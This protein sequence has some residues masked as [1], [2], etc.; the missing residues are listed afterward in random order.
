MFS[1]P[2]RAFTLI[3]LMV[4]VAIF[5]IISAILVPAFIRAREKG[6]QKVKPPSR[7]AQEAIPDGLPPTLATAE[8]KLDAQVETIREG[9]DV[10]NRFVLKHQAQ[11]LF[12]DGSDEPRRILIPFPKAT[13]L[14]NL[15]IRVRQ[16]D[17]WVEPDGLLI[18]QD[19]VVWSQSSFPVEVRLDY[20]ATGEG[21]LRYDWPQANRVGKL[22]AQL[23]LEAGEGVRAPL[24]SLRPDQV[25]P[26]QYS[27]EA[28]EILSPSPI[29]LEFSELD[30]PLARVGKL[31]RLT[32]LAL[33]FF[34]AGFWYLAELYRRG[35]LK[36]FGFGSFFLLALTYCSFFVSVAVLGF[37]GSL[38]AP[39]YLLL[40]LVLS[41]PLLL[42]HVSQLMDWR[43]AWSRALPWSMATLI[44]VLMGVYTSGA[45]R[46]Y[47]YLSF[48]LLNMAFL[49]TTYKP[50]IR[51]QKERELAQAGRLEEA[52]GEFRDLVDSARDLESRVLVW[53]TREQT[54]TECQLKP[55]VER[56]L[57]EMRQAREFPEWADLSYVQQQT[58]RLE[59][60]LT[61]L[62]RLLEQAE[63]LVFQQEEQ[64]PA[65]DLPSSGELHCLICGSPS[66]GGTYC[67]CCG[68]LLPLARDCSSCGQEVV[69]PLHLLESEQ[70]YHCQS[71][72]A[73]PR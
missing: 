24:G 45:V 38:Q 66:R 61:K 10:E 40:A 41:Q 5:A 53:L 57:E 54:K 46:N 63:D 12:E 18:R 44:L 13:R 43:F 8:V 55:L 49:T 1:R 7:T 33:L 31:F 27:W 29:L 15:A 65:S 56:R 6:L 26:D 39:A 69:I 20:Q 9:L 62:N 30:S 73:V 58:T 25:S 59:A 23:Q 67:S 22:S 17:K 72:G 16:G 14:E 71:C 42:F 2:T 37:D 51:V 34:G 4:V 50:F 19:M 21:S 11:F 35:S 36:D 52:R 64:E 32:G 68:G 28:S 70:P 60:T 48:G 47:G 3:E